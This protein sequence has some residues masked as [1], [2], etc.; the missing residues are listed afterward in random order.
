MYILIIIFGAALPSAYIFYS[1]VLDS[2]VQY[3]SSLYTTACSP[4]EAVSTVTVQ[5]SPFTHFF[6]SG[7]HYSNYPN[8]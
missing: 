7:N 4:V 1:I 3:N 5:L 2:C 8:F 6:S